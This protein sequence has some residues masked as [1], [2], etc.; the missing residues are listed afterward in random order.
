MRLVPT[1]RVQE[2]AELGK[3]VLVAR[4]DGIPLLRRGARISAD[5]RDRLILAGIHAIYIEDD[6]SEGIEPEQIITEETRALATRTVASTY[7]SV[8]S[9][10][11]TGRPLSDTTVEALSDIVARILAEIETS[12]GVALALADLASADAYTF[13]HSIDVAALGLLLGQRYYRQHGWLDYQG[14]RRFTRMHERLTQL[15]L[16]LMLHDIGKL[17]VPTEILNKPGKLDREE[18]AIMKSHV[19]LGVELLAGGEWTPLVKA[20]VLRHHERW[21]GSGYPDGKLG[22]EIHEMA[23]IA[24]I[25]DVYDAVTSQRPYAPARPACEGVRAI[26]DGAGTLF[27]RS[28]VE[29]FTSLVA[30]FPPGVEIELADGR[31]GVVVS[32]PERNLDRPLVRLL[33]GPDAQTEIDLAAHPAIRIAGWDRQPATVAA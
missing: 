9:A 24:A 10:M 23:R 8:Q 6:Q 3:D 33:D 19:R 2:G 5:Y 27:D 14:H 32:V 16:G 17:A 21:D 22:E 13:Q 15:G 20:I 29:V 30:P 11:S 12:G 18:W 1:A 7:Q 25:A 26:I 4:A 31:R 28:M